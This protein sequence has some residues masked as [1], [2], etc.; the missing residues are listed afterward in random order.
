MAKEILAVDDEEDILQLLR[1]VLEMEGFVVV[2]AR[3]GAEAL[4]VIASRRPDLIIADLMMPRVSGV[5]LLQRLKTQ[6]ETASIP[7]VVLSAWGDDEMVRIAIDVGAEAHFSKPFD[8]GELVR[9]IR[10]ELD[11]RKESPAGLG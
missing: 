6:A 11:E 5:M 7:V 2:T 10:R 4:E 9:F 1:F 8:S 3:D